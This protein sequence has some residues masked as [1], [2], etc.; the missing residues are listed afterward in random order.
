MNINTFFNDVDLD[1]NYNFFTETNRLDCKY[2]SLEE[3]LEN[4]SSNK[5]LSIFSR[6]IGSFGRNFECLSGAFDN[7]DLQCKMYFSETG[8]K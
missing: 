4:L 7:N 1:I 3:Y 6:N 5:D 8:F 2:F